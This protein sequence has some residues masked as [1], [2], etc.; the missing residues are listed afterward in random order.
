M[1]PSCL[2][3]LSLGAA[4]ADGA[5]SG[6]ADLFASIVF[7]PST[8]TEFPHG[9]YDAVGHNGRHQR[10]ERQEQEEHQAEKGS[11]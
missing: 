7:A 11:G 4:K 10:Q 1:L 9:H 6:V 5:V 8:L 2:S 3:L